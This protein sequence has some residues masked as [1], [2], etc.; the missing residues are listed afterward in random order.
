MYSH[1]GSHG[2]TE[3]ISVLSRSRLGFSKFPTPS[4]HPS[5]QPERPGALK[6]RFARLASQKQ[7]LDK[8]EALLT[9]Q[10]LALEAPSSLGS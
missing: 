5:P 9:A 3:V 6:R 2:G 8:Q 1:P 4:N 7:A 10:K